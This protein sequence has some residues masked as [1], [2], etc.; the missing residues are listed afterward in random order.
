MEAVLYARV[1]ISASSDKELS[2]ATRYTVENI[3]S[4]VDRLRLQS[5]VGFY[6]ADG[7]LTRATLMENFDNPPRFL[8]GAGPFPPGTRLR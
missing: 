1:A 8:A 3:T 5:T 2:R 7:E 6:N 4:A